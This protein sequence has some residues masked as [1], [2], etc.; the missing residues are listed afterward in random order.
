MRPVS[1]LPAHLES[2]PFTVSEARAANLS[3]GR[4]R[5]SDLASAGRLL[6][7]PA[8]WEFEL[9]SLARALSAATPGA[10][11]SH[12]TAA[13]LLGLWLPA[14][15]Q[16]CRDL[17]LSKPRSLPQVRRHGVVGHTVLAYDDEI[18]L[19]EGIRISTP[20]RTWLDLAR[21]LP[22][23]DLIALGDQLIRQPRQELELRS[24]PW[25]TVQELREM[26]TRHPKMQGIVKA[27]AAVEMIRAGADSAPETFL[28]LAMI[29]A[30]LPEPELQ[31]QIIP[32]DSYSPAA[33]LGY[34]R[35][36]IAIQYDGGH[37][38]TREQQSRDNRRDAAFFSAGWRYFKFN[39]DDLANDFHR[40]VGQVRMALREP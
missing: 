20:A 35:H 18:M 10:W 31:V 12:L 7:L 36:R 3:R 21:V 15:L 11:V 16:H 23:E 8:G 5:S 13:V 17:H 9:P 4:L 29:D 22:M 14:W 1:P 30:G 28:R 26:L 6:Y 24:Q 40:A 34:R 32:G 33:D 2:V 39:A 19:W 27:R 37:H 25:S 38:L